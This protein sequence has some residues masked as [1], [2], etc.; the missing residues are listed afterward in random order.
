MQAETFCL[1]DMGYKGPFCDTPI[2][3]VHG[4][5]SSENV[6]VCEPHWDGESCDRCAIDRR[7][8]GDECRL[9]VNEESLI[10]V[11]NQE[12]AE[13]W[14]LVAVGCAALALVV[15]VA[16]SGAVVLKRFHSK[17]SRVGSATA[18]DV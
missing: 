13:M 5:I 11:E 3:C 1:C 12:A 17:P 7:L 6:C 15:F 2:V 16:V 9:I 8:E 10:A 14:P 18:T 4:A